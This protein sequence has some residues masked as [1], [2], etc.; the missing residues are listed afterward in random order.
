VR[1]RRS[2]TLPDDCLVCREQRGE[3]E[4]PGGPLWEDELVFAFH[5]PPIEGSPRRYLGHLVVTPRRHVG[6]LEDLRD[7]EGAAIGVAAAR[8][9]RTLRGTLDLERVYSMVIGHAVPPHLHVHLV[10]RYRGTPAEVVWTAVDEWDGAP[11]GDA[12]DIA[13][14]VERLRTRIDA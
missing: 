13:A 14:L 3:V 9:A 1:R 10:P 12:Q 8:L 7:D 6:G 4:L 11:Y 5:V 2:A